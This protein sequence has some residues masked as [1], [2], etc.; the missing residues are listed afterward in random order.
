MAEDLL[1]ES[2]Y[3]LPQSQPVIELL[4]ALLRE[5]QPA[6]FPTETVKALLNLL[7]KHHEPTAAEVPKK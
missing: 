4:S 7:N 1:R 2:G 5:T 6:D 3:M